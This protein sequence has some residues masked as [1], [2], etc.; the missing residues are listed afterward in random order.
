[1]TLPI[2]SVGSANVSISENGVAV[3]AADPSVAWT[4]VDHVC[5]RCLGRVLAR[6][7]A[8]GRRIA[9]CA[10]CGLEAVGEHPAI[11]ACGIDTGAA[12]VRLRCERQAAPTAEYPSEIIATEA[13]I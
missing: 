7:D 8:D 2:G 9:R 1:V 12:K 11:C 6:T 5:R 3:A 4:I 13:P 10:D